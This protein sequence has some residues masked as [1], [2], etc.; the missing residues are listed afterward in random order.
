M[1]LTLTG[2]ATEGRPCRWRLVL[3]P[4]LLVT[5]PLETG[6]AQ[7]AAQLLARPVCVARREAVK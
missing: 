4:R 6:D 3:E 5:A 2:C 7:P 1:P